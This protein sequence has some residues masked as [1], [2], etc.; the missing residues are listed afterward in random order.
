MREQLLVLR[1]EITRIKRRLEAVAVAGSYEEL[2]AL[3]ER[4][5]VVEV[6][7]MDEGVYEDIEEELY[8]LKR[9]LARLSTAYRLAYMGRAKAR[10]RW[11]QRR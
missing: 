11:G 1:A 6:R 2:R 7:A 3:A 9:M 10:P 8:E 5:I 4:I